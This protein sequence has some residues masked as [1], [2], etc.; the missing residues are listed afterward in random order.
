MWEQL[1]LAAFARGAYLVN[2]NYSAPLLKRN[3]M[4]TV[5]DASVRAHPQTYSTRLPLLNNLM[6]CDAGAAR[7]TR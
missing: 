5:H 1:S 3:Q 4:I 7:A 6:V 2:A